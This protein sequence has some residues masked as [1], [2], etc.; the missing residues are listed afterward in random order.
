MM[1]TMEGV[2][3][4][5][6]VPVS[7]QDGM[8]ASREMTSRGTIRV[9]EGSCF[10]Q[11][12]R[13]RSHTWA[14]WSRPDRMNGI[15]AAILMLMPEPPW[16]RDFMMAL[17]Y[18]EEKRPIPARTNRAEPGSGASGKA[19]RLTY[20]QCPRC[21]GKIHPVSRPEAAPRWSIW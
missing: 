1:N 5:E 12:V 15:E 16:T 4:V 6:M 14:A 8:R 7:R 21:A 9:P 20:S 2:E 10:G 3:T 17:E 11:A 18:E 13:V 19:V